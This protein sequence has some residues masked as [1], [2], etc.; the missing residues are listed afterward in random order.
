[1]GRALDH[2]SLWARRV[3]GAEIVLRALALPL[4]GSDR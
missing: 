4:I 2:I 1:M 3:H